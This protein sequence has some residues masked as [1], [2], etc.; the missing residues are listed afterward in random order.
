MNDKQTEIDNVVLVIAQMMD[1]ILLEMLQV[2]NG[3][4][5]LM[6]SILV[7]RLKRLNADYENTKGFD[8]LL[9]LMLKIKMP[10]PV[11]QD[12]SEAKALLDKIS[13]RS[14]Q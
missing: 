11:M 2:T 9:Q 1:Q 10:T 4:V 5:Q 6:T 3:D 14:K 8:E 13:I 12:L 7:S